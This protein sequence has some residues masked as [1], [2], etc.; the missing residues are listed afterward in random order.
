MSDIYYEFGV[1]VLRDS[2]NAGPTGAEMRMAEEIKRLR[3]IHKRMEDMGVDN[4]WKARSEVAFELAELRAERDENERLRDRVVVLE[5]VVRFYADIHTWKSASV[6]MC[7]H[8]GNSRATIDRGEKA[9]GA[10]KDT[11]S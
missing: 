9:R 5:E 10:L 6:F 7:G 8:D 3:Y 2:E 1:D 11:T 4:V